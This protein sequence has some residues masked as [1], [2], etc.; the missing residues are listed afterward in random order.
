[1]DQ[2]KLL[3]MIN[4]MVLTACVEQLKKMP[5]RQVVLLNSENHSPVTLVMVDDLKRWASFRGQESL[6]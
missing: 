1:M 2:T 4:Q 6:N 5:A 3:Q